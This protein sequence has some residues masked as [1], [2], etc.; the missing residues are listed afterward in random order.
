MSV[1]GF[2]VLLT[3]YGA[4]LQHS[5][6][7]KFFIDFSMALMGHKADGAG[8]TVVLYWSYFGVIHPASAS[9]PPSMSRHRLSADPAGGFDAAGGLLAA[10]GLGAIIAAGASRAS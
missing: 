5:G 4:F 3:I 6:A 7:G 9:P 2:I 1:V 8:R 10:G